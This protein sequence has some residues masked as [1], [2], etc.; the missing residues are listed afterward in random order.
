MENSVAAQQTTIL[1]LRT[2]IKDLVNK[3]HGALSACENKLA[4][5]VS[6]LASS[7]ASLKQCS[8]DRDEA[9]INAENLNKIQEKQ[10]DTIVKLSGQ[11]ETMTLKH[12]RNSASIKSLKIKL[13]IETDKFNQATKEIKTLRDE[14]QKFKDQ[15]AREAAELAALQKQYNSLSDKTSK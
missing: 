10:Q 12:K 9:R 8:K 15:V 7:D 1:A 14:V 3:H 4:T 2:E 11:V 5:A 6:Q 13:Q